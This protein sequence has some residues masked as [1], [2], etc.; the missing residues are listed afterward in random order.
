[1]I[2]KQRNFD[3]KLRC[4]IC[5]IGELYVLLLYFFESVPASYGSDGKNKGRF[6]N[7]DDG[8]VNVID[9]VN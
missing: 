6:V 4:Y 7:I 9:F 1:M 3:W 2:R 5:I 8:E